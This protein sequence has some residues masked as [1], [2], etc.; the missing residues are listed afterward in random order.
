MT[1]INLSKNVGSHEIKGNSKVKVDLKD[2]SSEINKQTDKDS[3]VIGDLKLLK[4]KDNERRKDLG[5]EN[6]GLNTQIERF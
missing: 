4:F 5:K 3:E 6:K 2:E 1:G